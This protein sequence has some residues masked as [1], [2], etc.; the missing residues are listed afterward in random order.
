MNKQQQQRSR[1]WKRRPFQI[2]SIGM[3]KSLTIL[4]LAVLA[5][6]ATATKWSMEAEIDLGGY[7]AKTFT[8]SEQ[9]KFRRAVSDS[10]KIPVSCVTIKFFENSA[11]GT[12]SQLGVSKSVTVTF[13]IVVGS[14]SL[15]ERVEQSLENDTFFMQFAKAMKKEG[16]DPTKVDVSNV[17]K[18]EKVAT[19]MAVGTMAVLG[20]AGLVVFAVG[21]YKLQQLSSGAGGAAGSAEERVGLAS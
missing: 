20:G 3:F 8:K 6:E 11:A 17:G 18:I 4:L 19:K 14:Q 10:L 16:L 21:A 13:S 15:S 7:T 12:E 9:G 5:Q 1:V 2:G